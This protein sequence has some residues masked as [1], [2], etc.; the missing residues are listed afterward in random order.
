MSDII[1]VVSKQEFQISMLP[2]ATSNQYAYLRAWQCHWAMSHGGQSVH[3]TLNQ[4]TGHFISYV[5]CAQT[6]V[7]VSITCHPARAQ[8]L[9]RTSSRTS[10]IG[11]GTYLIKSNTSF[12]I[13]I[14]CKSIL[15]NIL[16]N[17]I[18]CSAIVFFSIVNQRRLK[19]EFCGRH[20][21]MRFELGYPLLF[22]YFSM[23]FL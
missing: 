12:A 17:C 8:L 7:I 14:I 1:D 4:G 18:S 2:M 11:T 23:W 19:C 22:Q 15:C 6:Q 13:I 16:Y 10:Q 21:T 20:M 9:Q 3:W 5:L